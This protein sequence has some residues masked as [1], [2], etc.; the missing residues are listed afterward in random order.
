[1]LRRGG[2]DEPEVRPRGARVRSFVRGLVNLVVLVL[3]AGGVGV[4]LGMGLAALSGSDEP[5]ATDVGGTATTATEA[6]RAP[7]ATTPAQTAAAAPAATTTATPPPVSTTTTPAAARVSASVL[8]ARLFTDS[9]PSGRQEQRARVTVRIRAANPGP[10][11]ATL[12]PPVLRVGSVRIPADPEGARFEPLGPGTSQ[13]VTL[14][15]EL[16][17]EA[18]PKVVRD[19]RARILIAGQSLPMRV[20]V[21]APTQ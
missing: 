19:R 1:M 16:A 13:T 8:D 4:A 20:K 6:V 14:R 5:A 17:G 15:F 7:Q 3:I 21:Q 2:G 12:D 11:R 10:E 18:T 9:T